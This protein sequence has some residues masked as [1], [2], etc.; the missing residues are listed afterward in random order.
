MGRE[1]DQQPASDTAT[2]WDEWMEQHAERPRPVPDVAD[3]EG[4]VTPDTTPPFPEPE[5]T[6]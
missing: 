6:P 4:R 3:A 1:K 2:D 5:K